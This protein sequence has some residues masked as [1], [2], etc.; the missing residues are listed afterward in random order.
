MTL[1]T[2]FWILAFFVAYGTI[3][4]GFKEFFSD[5]AIALAY[6]VAGIIRTYKRIKKFLRK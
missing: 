5:L 1:Q 4:N 2:V 6:I 3:K